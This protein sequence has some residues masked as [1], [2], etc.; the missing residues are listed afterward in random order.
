MSYS[1]REKSRGYDRRGGYNKERRS[2]G[3]KS[4]L[5]K[6][7]SKIN[8]IDLSP[9]DDR[10]TQRSPQPKT[11][12]LPKWV[13]PVIVLNTWGIVLFVMG[14]LLWLTGS[15]FFAFFAF[16]YVAITAVRR[17]NKLEIVR[18]GIVTRG[19]YQSHERVNHNVAKQSR[20][21][22]HFA[23]PI[24]DG[25]IVEGSV[26]TVHLSKLRDDAKEI[27]VYHRENPSMFEPLDTLPRWCHNAILRHL[28]QVPLAHG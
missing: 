19:S 16:A 11:G 3:G 5:G 1:R 21:A 8:D 13:Y 2:R 7:W 12:E 17:L 10:R 26:E 27:L 4:W 14:M 20:Y 22:V 25:R 9:S 6:I 28:P 18:H 15:G 23:F 24:L